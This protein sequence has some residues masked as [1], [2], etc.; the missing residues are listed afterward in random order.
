M[1][2]IL[3]LLSFLFIV[4]CATSKKSGSGSS[5]EGEIDSWRAKRLSALK[6]PEGWFSL[7][8]LYWLES[9]QATIGSDPSADIVFPENAP[10]RVG[11]L[12]R[13]GEAF[14]LSVPDSVS[15]MIDN[16]KVTDTLLQTDMGDQAPTIVEHGSFKWHIINRGRRF[17]IRLKD[18]LQ[19]QRVHIPEILYF[20]VSE[21]WKIPATFVA[22]KEK[23]TIPIQNVIGMTIPTQVKGHLKFSFEEKE[24]ELLALEGGNQSYFVIFADKTT[25]LQTYGGGRY[26][27]VDIADE[28]GQTFID[29]NKAYNPPCVFTEYATCPLPPL[30]NYLTFE[31]QAGEKKVP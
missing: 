5:Y 19:V 13:V 2:R 14:A 4:A 7:V 27:D 28:N 30:E 21:K 16:K 31:V 22:T 12:S 15:V 18:T 17:G 3:P 29:F 9:D 10:F 24:H 26:L 20:P 1:L 25:Y 11:Q 23:V 8:G 6:S